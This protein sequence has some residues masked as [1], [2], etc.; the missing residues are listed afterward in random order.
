MRS[1]LEQVIAIVPE[2]LQQ[3]LRNIRAPRGT[4]QLSF[5]IRYET[6]D[7]SANDALPFGKPLECIDSVEGHRE[8]GRENQER[9]MQLVYRGVGKKKRLMAFGPTRWG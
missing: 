8:L 6:V 4:L 3:P 9:R 1:A 7:V 5:R 2:R